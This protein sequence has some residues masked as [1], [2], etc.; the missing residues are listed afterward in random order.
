MLSPNTRT[1]TGE[2]MRSSLAES[3]TPRR[4][5]PKNESKNN[6]KA[7]PRASHATA[8]SNSSRP[9]NFIDG[10][11]P[12]CQ[13]VPD[14]VGAVL[15]A[16]YHERDD[17]LDPADTGREHRKHDQ[18][19]D[20]QCDDG[21]A[22]VSEGNYGDESEQRHG[23]EAL[24]EFVERA[25]LVV[26]DL[27]EGTDVADVDVE[28]AEFDVARKP[29]RREQGIHAREPRHRAADERARPVRPAEACESGR[30]NSIDEKPRPEE[31]EQ[32]YVSRARHR[33][34]DEKREKGERDEIAHDLIK[35]KSSAA[36]VA[37]QRLHRRQRLWM[38]EIALD[39]L[40]VTRT[41]HRP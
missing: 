26:Q 14:E 18:R 22:D 12:S 8:R 36:F 27:I 31:F 29:A 6:A 34:Q 23:L 7:I 19:E 3:N 4:S 35:R 10:S 38:V 32:K 39:A 40:H 15:R 2:R 13:C 41:E 21:A 33:Q 5:M 16:L 30:K 11:P 1:T 24:P 37:L 28:V 17:S 25:F 9:W 20:Y